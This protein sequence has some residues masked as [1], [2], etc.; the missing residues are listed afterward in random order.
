MAMVRPED[1][2]Y[3][4]LENR[5]DVQQAATEL[6]QK[7]SKHLQNCREVLSDLKVKHVDIRN[8]AHNISALLADI[9]EAERLLQKDTFKHHLESEKKLELAQSDVTK[10]RMQAE[11]ER[12][13][14]I[15]NEEALKN[16]GRNLAE[17]RVQF[18]V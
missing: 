11:P 15:K 14:I 7:F 8:A 4:N 12:E 6:S 9:K 18:G 16:L 17:L 2:E 13:N 1:L 5:A 10:L 3:V